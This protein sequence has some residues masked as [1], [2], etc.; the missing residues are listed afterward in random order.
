LQPLCKSRDVVV[1]AIQRRQLGR[2][3]AAPQAGARL[4]AALILVG[5]RRCS[6]GWQQRERVAAPWNGR[7]RAR[8]QQLAQRPDLHLQVAFLDDALGPDE[9]EQ[10]VL[11]H[12]LAGALDQRQ[13]QVE[14]ARRDVDVLA[15]QAQHTCTGQ[16]F[17]ALELV[18]DR[19]HSTP[20]RSVTA[21]SL[22]TRR[23]SAAALHSTATVEETT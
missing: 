13:Q 15:V 14:G 8:T 23:P 12:Q 20:R 17:E 18:Y 6:R 4:R 2:Q 5:R 1:A 3:V 16:Q 10:L 22:A 11:R 19:L 21:G 7:D 9:F